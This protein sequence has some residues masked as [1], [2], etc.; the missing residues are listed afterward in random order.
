METVKCK[1]LN[2][3]ITKSIAMSQKSGGDISPL[4]I[5]KE[6]RQQTNKERKKEQKR[7]IQLLYQSWEMPK[8]MVRPV[9]R[10]E[11]PPPASE[12]FQPPF[13]TILSHQ[14]LLSQVEDF[15]NNYFQCSNASLSSALLFSVLVKCISNINFHF[16]LTQEKTPAMTENGCVFLP[17]QSLNSTIPSLDISPSLQLI[18]S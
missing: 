16:S 6:R 3:Q 7:K 5:K 15:Q 18:I 10:S 8:N 12:S 2:E 11:H 1:S 4:D 13:E 9:D 14:S 17:Q